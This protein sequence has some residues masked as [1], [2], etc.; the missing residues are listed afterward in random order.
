[1]LLMNEQIGNK[2]NDKTY[3][4]LTPFKGF[5]LENFPF[6]EADFDAITNYQLLCKVIEY[7][8]NVISNQNTVQEL[9]T[10]LVNAYNSLVDAVNLAI[11]EF[12]TDV[13]ADINQFKVDTNNDINQFKTDITTQFNNLKNYVD[14]YFDN[15]FPELVSDKLDEMAEDG[16][17]ENLINDTAHLIKVYN[18]YTDMI[19]DSSTFTNGLRLKTMGY[20]NVNDGG[21]AEYY[22][23]NTQNTT[24][25]QINLQNGLYVELIFE[26]NIINPCQ[27]GAKHTEGQDDSSVLQSCLDLL[28]QHKF[29]C[30]DLQDY[31]YYISSPLHLDSNYNCY[32]QNGQIHA[33]SNFVLDNDT[34]KN[35]LLYLTN[36]KNTEPSGYYGHATN[37]LSLINLTF[38]CKLISGLGCLRLKSL[39]IMTINNCVF[40]RYTTEGIMFSDQ[41]SHE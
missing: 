1:M 5:V 6:I 21:G 17:L 2:I 15:N 14:N 38:D 32:I 18:T 26:N 27:L 19:A 7:L 3:I 30:L 22:V 37:D 36:V 29:K 16:T 11:N 10:D 25:Y 33:N 35:Y 9:G 39:L 20:Y 40:H 23:T 4:K 31:I 8:N 24:T 13:T 41:Y 34:T 28:H 12:E